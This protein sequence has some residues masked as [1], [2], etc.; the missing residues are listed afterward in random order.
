[1]SRSEAREFSDLASELSARCLEAIEQNRLEDIPADALGQA[2]ASV[3]QL[4]A[5]KAQA[6]EGMLPFG[7]NSGVTATDVAIG[8]TAMLEAVNLALFELGAWQNMSSVGR[9]K[10]DESVTERY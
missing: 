4:Y 9:I 3:L 1:M 6:G 2:F 7:R 5:A 10:Y 8:C